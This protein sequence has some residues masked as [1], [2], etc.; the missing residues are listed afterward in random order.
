MIIQ[1]GFIEFKRKQQG[2]IDPVS[3]FPVKSSD[4]GWSNPIPCQWRTVNADLLRLVNGERFPAASYEVLI[5]EQPIPTEQQVRLSDSH[6]RSLGEFSL[7]AAAEPLEA[8]SQI[9]LLI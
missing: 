2:G 5:E 3:G 4:I 9:K 8:V 6:G 7:K 1:N